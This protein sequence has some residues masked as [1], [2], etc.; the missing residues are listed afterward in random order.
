ML[1]RNPAYFN[2]Q[3]R[4]WFFFFACLFFFPTLC[5]FVCFSGLVLS[6]PSSP[7]LSSALT[8]PGIS[9]GEMIPLAAFKPVSPPECRHARRRVYLH[10]RLTYFR[11]A[12]SYS[13][14]HTCV[15][16]S[17]LHRPLLETH[18]FIS[19]NNLLEDFTEE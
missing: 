6:S 7:P 16:Q 4:I 2:R 3:H 13:V 1:L 10:C 18:T 14:T 9:S 12:S 15:H 19:L 5:L 8:P 17:G 11:L